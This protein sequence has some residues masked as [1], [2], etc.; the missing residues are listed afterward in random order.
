MLIGTHYSV[1]FS[2]IIRSTNYKNEMLDKVKI[3][4]I[5]IA[6]FLGFFKNGDVHGSLFVLTLQS[7][8]FMDTHVQHPYLFLVHK[9][10]V[11]KFSK[12]AEHLKSS[13]FS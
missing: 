6:P 3:G 10:H 9:P 13:V 12:V 4:K 11:I 1:L 8:K 2:C 5:F 7:E